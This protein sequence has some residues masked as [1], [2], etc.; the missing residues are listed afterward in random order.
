MGRLLG[1]VLPLAFGAAV[2]PTLLAMQLVMLSRK[3]APLGRAWAFAAGAAV[4]LAAFAAVALLVARSTGGPSSPSEA[5]AIVKLVAAA[6]LLVLGVRTMRRAPQPAKPEHVAARPE[7]RAFAV[8]AGLMLTNFSSIVLF[9]PAMHAIGISKV[10]L[11]GQVVAFV[12]LYAITLLPAY[13]PPLIV[14]VMGS[15]ATPL[16]QALDRFFAD[17]K[18]GI[19]AG[20]CFVFALLLAVAGLKVLL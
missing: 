11:A 2:S 16:L 18:R 9:F 15:R 12:L 17:H 4:V 7:E 14:T 20:I 6:L 3:T 13:G 5:G 19:S 8:G 10:G 1:I